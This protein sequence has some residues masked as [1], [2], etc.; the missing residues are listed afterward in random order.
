[1]ELADLKR[2]YLIADAWRDLG[3]AGAPGKSVCS[4][5]RKD[6][7]PSFSIWADGMKAKDFATGESFDVFDF[8]SRARGCNTAEAIAFV[9]ERLGVAREPRRPE[10]PPPPR[11]VPKLPPLRAGT[12][13][14]L[15][16]LAER[17]GFAVEALTLAQERG[18]LFFGGLWGEPAWCITDQ[19]RQLHEFRRV[20]CEKWPAYG[21]LPARKCHCL[22]QGKDWPIGTL[23]SAPF[24]K[25]AWVE[26]A[27]DLLAAFHF[28]RA[29]Q[30]TETVAPVGILGASNRALAPDAL[31]HFKGKAVCLYPHADD[32]GREAARSWARQLKDAGA[33]RVTAFDLSGLM[34]RDGTTG[35]DLADVALLSAES[36]ECD[37]KWQEVMP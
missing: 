20:D 7:S 4:P 10:P 8:V 24:G 13:G 17:R 30:K 27:P 9:R 2:R 35:K 22:G 32:A 25:I 6:N 31:A 26:G 12:D 14:E 29:E 36:F 21:R 1:M 37:T 3:L 19:R 16:Q 23:E 33:A 18:F 5:L 28:L 15:R 11:P 34:K